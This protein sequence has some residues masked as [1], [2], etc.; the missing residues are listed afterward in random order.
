M[1]TKHISELPIE[2]QETL[3]KTYQ[4][5]YV[6]VDPVTNERYVRFMGENVALASIKQ[7]QMLLG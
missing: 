4:E 5:Y 6:N 1:T 7:H 2:A 3:R